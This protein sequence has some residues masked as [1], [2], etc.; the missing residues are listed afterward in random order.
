MKA[1]TETGSSGGE[2]NR[3][4]FSLL[5]R[6]MEFYCRPAGWS[7]PLLALLGLLLAGLVTALWRSVARLR[8][9]A[10]AAGLVHLL[11]LLA[12]ALFLRQLPRRRIS[13]GP[14]KAQAVV[15]ATPRTAAALAL[16]LLSSLLG[17]SGT[18]ALQVG[19]QAL[20]T[21]LLYWGAAVE[22]QRLSLTQIELELPGLPAGGEPIRLLHISD[23]HMERPTRREEELIA[24]AEVAQPD[25]IVI[26]GDFL[27]LSYNRDE[28]AVALVQ[29]FLRRLHA[30]YGVY[31]TLGS[32]PVDLRDVVPHLFDS[33]PTRLL[34]DEWLTVDTG[35]GRH[36]H[37]LGL[38]CTHY[39]ERD[40]RRLASLNAGRP[41]GSVHVLLYH[42]P[43]L[44]P[45]ASEASF[46]L[47]LCGHTHGGQI[48]LPGIG[49]II[50]SSQLGR[51]YV[52]GH[53]R[54]QGTHLY[55][56][57]GVGLEGLSAPR[58]RFFSPPEI[59]LFTLRPPASTPGAA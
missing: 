30:P 16:P 44:M 21:A 9:V 55:V 11:F 18:L 52:M 45:E 49:P 1:F 2:R 14:W 29:Q 48:R 53:Y 5:H 12:D 23:V 37:L 3:L 39:R 41:A 19:L 17:A 35:D 22:P 50:T 47:Y 6:A 4:E 38:D 42:S 57:R 51:R 15:L 40:A 10:F 20:G 26:T 34:R 7:P 13:F 27:N 8:H 25:V 46:D 32:P 33:V 59:T 28:A 56:S 31:A 24:L 54:E 43:E 58:I 36:L